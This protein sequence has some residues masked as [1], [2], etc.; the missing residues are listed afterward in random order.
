MASASSVFVESVY[1]FIFFDGFALFSAALSLSPGLNSS[2]WHV[3]IVC[4]LAP[5]ISPEDL[6]RVC[7]VRA[8]GKAWISWH[9]GPTSCRVF[10]NRK[11]LRNMA[12]ER[13]KCS[14]QSQVGLPMG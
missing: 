11:Q 5:R 3:F 12:G 13:F 6:P 8:M 2:T 9:R 4:I 7:F 1:V 10:S 14:M